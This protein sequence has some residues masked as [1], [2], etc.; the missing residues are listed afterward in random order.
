MKIDKTWE[1]GEGEYCEFEL[2]FL[3]ITKKYEL[4]IL[5]RNF[6]R[7]RMELYVIHLKNDVYGID[8]YEMKYVMHYAF[9]E[10]PS[11][12]NA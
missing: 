12:E 11:A 7:D 9:P 5:I 6:T 2:Q 4:F 8:D 3:K 10:R 1:N